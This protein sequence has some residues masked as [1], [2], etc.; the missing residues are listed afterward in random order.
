M[1]SF[2]KILL[3]AALLL[4]VQGI[5]AQLPVPVE[6]LR[7]YCKR[8]VPV[9]Y[10]P[11]LNA[12]TLIP[13]GNLH[14]LFP[15]YHAFKDEAKFK[16]I[17]TEK[18]YYNELSEYF[19]FAG[20]YGT[21]MTYLEKSYDSIDDGTRRKVFRMV[22]GIGNVEHADAW[23]YI[24]F[25]ARRS[26]V[27]MINEAHDKPQHSAFVLSLLADLYKVGY[28]LLA[29]E[30]L[31]NTSTRELSSLRLATGYYTAEPVTGELVRNALA[32]GYKL[33]A[34]EDTLTGHTPTTRDSIQAANIYDALREDTSAKMLVL[35]SYGHISKKAAPDGFV[36]MALAFK[37]M[38]GIDPLIIDQTDMTEESNFGYGRVLYQAYLQKF[39]LKT[40]SIALLN[41]TPVNVIHG[42]LYDL[43]V[44]HPPTIYQDGRPTWLNLGGQRQP[45]PIKPSSPAVFLVQA[46]YQD[47]VARNENKPWQL[48]PADQTY[49]AG[50]KKLYLLYLKKGK[51]TVYFRNI[52]YHILNTL[53]IEV[54]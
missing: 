7:D 22:E 11:R 14:Y 8:E 47:E 21:A 44:I 53:D 6:Q 13:K 12:L 45:I 32:I 46:Y 54:N 18:G 10:S 9:G 35:A 42:D 50:G 33:V 23:K 39:P 15:L 37:R 51:Y 20:D 27:V 19:A 29:M 48:V 41:N 3:L 30:M 36:P 25:A 43:S 1:T 26:K 17:Y 34:Y 16:N 24:H 38:S 52:D 28:R 2:R 49:I 31:N 4:A 5:F 40:P